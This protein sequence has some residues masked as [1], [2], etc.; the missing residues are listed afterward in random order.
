[1]RY[2]L[3]IASYTVQFWGETKTMFSELPVYISQFSLF[4]WIVSLYHN[5]DLITHNCEFISQFWG[6]KSQNLKTVCIAQIL[7]KSENCEIEKSQ[8]PF[9][10][11]YSVMEK[12]FH[13][14]NLCKI[15]ILISLI[16]NL[17]N[18]TLLNG[19]VFNLHNTLILIY[20]SVENGDIQNVFYK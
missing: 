2:K 15:K 12:G 14:I 19:C 4:L 8:L 10:F 20:N 6:K 3:T 11:F 7:E 17:T 5:S 16:K 9:L 13:W 1:M 18:H